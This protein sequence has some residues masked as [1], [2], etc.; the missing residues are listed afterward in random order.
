[1]KRTVIARLLILGLFGFVP[2]LRSQQPIPIVA[3]SEVSRATVPDS[4]G[5]SVSRLMRFTGVLRN[6][7]GTARTGVQGLAF[8]LYRDEKDGSPLWME[9]LNAEADTEGRYVALLGSTK[10]EGLPIE[11]FTTGEA[12]W[13]GIRGQMPW[14]EEHRVLL[15]SV[16]YALKA[17]DAETL[18]GKPLSAFVLAKNST[19]TETMDTR[20]ASL[21]GLRDDGGPK[22]VATSPI[23]AANGTVGQIAMFTTPTDLS[24][25]VMHQMSGR[26]GVGNTLPGH[27][28][29]VGSR[30][31]A[32]AQ[33]VAL[34]VVGDTGSAWKGAAAF[35]H[36]NAAVIMGEATGTASIG[37]H[38]GALDAWTNL[39]INGGG[40][41]VG[42]GNGT[43]QHRLHVGARSGA[44]AQ[45]VSL[46]VNGETTGPWKGSAAFGHDSASVM[47]GEVNGAAS[48]AGHSSA[49]DAAANLIINGGGGNVGIGTATPAEKLDV[50]G[51]NIKVSGKFLGDGGGIT[52]LNADN[53]S[54]GTVA[55]SRTT[56]TS[57]YAKNTIVLR[58]DTGSF[59]AGS[60]RAL[61][62]GVARLRVE[63]PST[64]NTGTAAISVGGYGGVSVDA[65][66]SPGGRFTVTEGGNVGI[67]NENPGQ[68]LTVAGTVQSASGGFMFPDGS[69]Q[70]QAAG[71]TWTAVRYT[72]RIDLPPSTGMPVSVAHLVV[73]PG[74]YFI[75]AT[76]DFWNGNAFAAQDN[77]RIVDCTFSGEQQWAQ[78]FETDVNG[79]NHRETATYTTVRTFNQASAIDLT[80]IV[81]NQSTGTTNVAAA[82][83]RITA[84]QIGPVTAQSF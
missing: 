9:T 48:L 58:D 50:A 49:L 37:A 51:G 24:D 33:S 30:A 68:K 28:F 75:S 55:N 67:G 19:S 43:P 66:G 61:G 72:P 6:A 23:L 82:R 64:P 35:G 25:S 29:H 69:V 44:D 76:I 27:L 10:S 78:S 1:M 47:L 3:D 40:G 80:C 4:G 13:L 84:I 59:S 20:P 46:R 79:F 15:V 14:D 21:N 52:H 60:I 11:L 22:S 16:P 8:A 31:L 32:D 56:A 73:P 71:A 12:R 18:G 42:I 17:L 53:L 74:N 34:R 57:A 70:T 7:D 45:P 5:V 77:S 26:I 83:R 54:T 39:V 2:I 63:G 62:M 38:S 65:F 36:D 81:A 41:N